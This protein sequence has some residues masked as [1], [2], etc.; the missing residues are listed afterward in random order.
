M[1]KSK[2]E[3]FICRWIVDHDS[4]VRISVCSRLQEICVPIDMTAEESPAVLLHCSTL[5]WK[6]SLSPREY[7]YFKR[8]LKEIKYEMIYLRWKIKMRT[9]M[10]M[11]YQK[12]GWV[13]G[14]VWNTAQT[15]EQ[16]KR[17]F[18]AIRVCLCV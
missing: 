3:K 2:D 7:T 18:L 16:E 10:E 5:K 17:L 6:L 13:D 15:V 9:R 14:E 12:V 11:M 8:L 4:S 1:R